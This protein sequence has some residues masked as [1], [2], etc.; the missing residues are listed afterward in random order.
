MILPNLYNYFVKVMLY[1]QEPD[2]SNAASLLGVN[3]Y[4]LKDYERAAAN[5]PLQ[6]LARCIE[7][8]HDADRKCKGIN[9]NTA[10][11]TDGEIL[12]ELIFKIIH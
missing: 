3:P 8:L 1:H 10:T 12:K 9:N 5:Y 11:T 4:F 6:K 7:Y 2:K